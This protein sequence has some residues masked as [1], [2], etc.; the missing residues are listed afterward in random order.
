MGT[1]TLIV[2]IAVSCWTL[3]ACFA[4]VLCGAAR[5][6]DRADQAEPAV[7]DVSVREALASLAT[8]P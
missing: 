6:G 1:L 5:E 4:V 8:R 3:A 7:A 2:V